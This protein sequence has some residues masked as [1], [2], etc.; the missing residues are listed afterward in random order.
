MNTSTDL[1][2]DNEGPGPRRRFWG[3]IAL[4]MLWVGLAIAM[5]GTLHGGG[6]E[7]AEGALSQ[8]L[9]HAGEVHEMLLYSPSA[10]ARLF[11][12]RIW[13]VTLLLLFAS[14]FASG[15]EV[16][17]FSLHPVRLRGMRESES[18]LDRLVARLMEHPGDLLTSI[19]I[20]NNIVNVL[21]GVVIGARVEELFETVFAG[22]MSDLIAYVLAVVLCTAI[23][24]IFGEIIP[25]MIVVYNGEAFARF[26]APPL[27]VIDRGLL[28]LR[29]AIL[30]L[31][32]FIFQVTRFSEVRPAPFMT[33]EEFK[34]VLSDGEATGVIQEDER[35]MIQ[36][37]L[38]FS[39]A[40]IREILVPR[41]EMVALKAN[42]SVAEALEVVREHEYSRIPIYQDDLDH[43]VGVLIAKDLLPVAVSGRTDQPIRPLVRKAHFVPETMKVADFVRHAQRLR[44]HLAIVVDEYGGTRGLVTLQ[45]AIREVVGDI[46]E[47]DDLDQ[48]LCEPAGI[49]CFRVDGRFPLD[50][51][52]EIVGVP[53]KDEE[54]ST[55][56]GFLM[57]AIDHM[58]EPGE[59]I[60]HEGISYTIEG[61]EGKR[62]TC[63]KM[64]LLEAPPKK[65]PE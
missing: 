58:P 13:F 32:R 5:G 7:S 56:A 45:D 15:S 50:E 16:A 33:D 23:L 22:A 60:E 63:V 34:S 52:E 62:I 38:E 65:E 55:L 40:V 41:P 46:G 11:P 61:V 36:G 30:L 8:T 6:T 25:K 42:A 1:S 19:L 43:I 21:I 12:F 28:P 10:W 18:L 9:A 20:S 57:D 54:H 27:I 26:A 64:R 2:G 44:T 48:L 49:G 29:R 14:A 51:L 47:E 35:N 37:I 4:T 39:D 17:L 31:V 3:R 53:L 59:E 24:V